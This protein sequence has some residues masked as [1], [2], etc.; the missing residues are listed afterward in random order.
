MKK[1][2]IA[3]LVLGLAAPAMAAEVTISGS[4]WVM[5]CYQSQDEDWSGIKDGDFGGSSDGITAA[6]NNI[7]YIPKAGKSNNINFHATASDTLSSWVEIGLGPAPGGQADAAYVKHA[8]AKWKFGAGA[9]SFGWGEALDTWMAAFPVYVDA[10]PYIGNGSMYHVRKSLL[11]LDISGFSVAI[12]ENTGNPNGAYTDVD[13]YIPEIAASYAWA[14]KM[15]FIKGAGGFQT[16]SITDHVADD[17]LTI[18]SYDVSLQTR[19]SL[20]PAYIGLGGYYAVN[21]SDEGFLVFNV[22]GGYTID[23]NGDV[24]DAKVAGGSLTAGV[25][26]NPSLGFNAGFIYQTGERDE[27]SQNCV[28]AFVNLDTKLGPIMVTPEIGYQA[29]DEDRGSRMYV[30]TL[31]KV[32]W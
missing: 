9:L 1:L 11:Q 31:F 29:K 28:N 4:N 23:A 5:L 7:I 3:L 22:P 6:Q 30:S 17:S 27:N 24:Q 10:G 26:L 19:V 32:F 25:K 15:L 21:P 2:L 13:A 20:G 14:N 16:Y 12:R 8:V 18:N